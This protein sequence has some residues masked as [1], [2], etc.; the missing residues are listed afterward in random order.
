[1][2]TRQNERYFHG[3]SITK[4]RRRFEK[5]LKLISFPPHNNDCRGTSHIRNTLC[6]PEIRVPRRWPQMVA[7]DLDGL[8]AL[9]SISDT[10]VL[11]K[12]FCI[13][14]TCFLCIF[15]ASSVF[16]IRYNSDMKG[17]TPVV[18]TRSF[19]W[20]VATEVLFF[21]TTTCPGF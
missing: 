20:R 8:Y 12:Y 19:S 17:Y 11:T 10:S 1:M 14:F 2:P 16:R 6:S 3:V 15:C 18:S 13:S 9:L 7:A 4:S 5:K 21:C